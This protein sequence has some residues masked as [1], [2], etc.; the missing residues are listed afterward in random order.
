MAGPVG[1]SSHWCIPCSVLPDG[2]PLCPDVDL[3]RGADSV[4]SEW[5][6]KK[7]IAVQIHVAGMLAQYS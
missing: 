7:D 4:H 6:A 5:H 3:R 1:W 2:P